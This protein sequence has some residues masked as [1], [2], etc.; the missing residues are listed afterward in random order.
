MGFGLDFGT[1]RRE[2]IYMKMLESQWRDIARGTDQ[3][4]AYLSSI[5]PYPNFQLFDKNNDEL[6]NFN[7][8]RSEGDKIY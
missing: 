5:S 4:H 2:E 8:S 7:F 6:T 3:D 1:S